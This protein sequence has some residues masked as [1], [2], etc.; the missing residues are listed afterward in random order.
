MHL[1]AQCNLICADIVCH[2]NDQIVH[3]CWNVIHI[4]DQVKQLQQ[5][6]VLCFDSGAYLGGFLAALNHSAD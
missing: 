1:L 5:R 2:Q 6:D 4:A 3:I